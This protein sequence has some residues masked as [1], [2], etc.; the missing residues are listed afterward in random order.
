MDP[1]AIAPIKPDS[2]AQ[3]II[4]TARNPLLALNHELVI[5]AASQSYYDLFKVT[6][7]QIIGTPVFDV[8]GDLNA[9][10]VAPFRKLMDAV[11]AD[12]VTT[13]M[14]YELDFT[15]P[16]TA[17]PATIYLNARR[18][19]R[20]SDSGKT[21]I[22]LLTHEDI[23]V[24]VAQERALA[25]LKVIADKAIDDALAA[26]VIADKAIEDADE[27]K[28]IALD[29]SDFSQSVIDTVREPMIAL[30]SDLRVIS[31]SRSFY[32]FFQVDPKETMG[33]LIY[34]LGNKQ[35][36]IPKLRDLLEN[37][38]PSKSAFDNYEVIHEFANIGKRIMVLNARQLLRASGKDKTIL[39][40][41][42]DVTEVREAEGKLEVARRDLALL[43][44]G[45]KKK[46]ESEINLRT[47]ELRQALDEIKSASLETI[48]RLSMAAEYRDDDT[49]QHIKRMS[50]YCATIARTMG[51]PDSVVD[52][53]LMATPMH[54]IGKIGIPDAILLKPAKLDA[55]EWEVMKTH[56]AIGGNILKGSGAEFIRMA[57][58]I[59]R[60]HHEKWDGSG[61][62]SGLKGS[63]IPLP[64]RIA[65]LADVYDALTSQRPY[66]E[67]FSEEKALSIMEE[68]KGIHFDPDVYDAFLAS[69]D[70]II[71]FKER[72]LV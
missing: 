68:G 18:I 16:G 54:D 12:D 15:Y 21:E 19:S 63:N 13:D 67:I 28:K 35:W 3:G 8:A 70:K 42:D 60:S 46:L 7:E 33:Y 44:V 50:F 25:V 55:A 22:I 58:L 57:E 52:M 17:T 72:A 41:F 62:P 66:K 1:I 71:E 38:L 40:A 23:T 29:L 34:D 11:L 47:I 51:Q 65:A 43:A 14:G 32:E 10:G 36:N 69:Y 49:G 20:S 45:A 59:A 31:V 6:P 2:F 24:R 30:D 53:I 48:H 61:Y 27:A 4:E 39:L 26:K 56:A 9:P 5:V 64:G 37:I